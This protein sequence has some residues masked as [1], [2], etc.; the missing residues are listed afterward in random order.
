MPSS[1]SVSLQEVKAIRQLLTG[2]LV[3]ALSNQEG[4]FV[5]ILTWSRDTDGALGGERRGEEGQHAPVLILTHCAY[6]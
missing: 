4:Q 3:D 6:V 2:L 1:R 5:G